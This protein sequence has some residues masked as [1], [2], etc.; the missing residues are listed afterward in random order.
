MVIRL[1]RKFLSC[2]NTGIILNLNKF[3]TESSISL[4]GRFHWLIVFTVMAGFLQYYFF[5]ILFE[6]VPQSI[7][8]VNSVCELAN[9]CF[10][11]HKIFFSVYFPLIFWPYS[12]SPLRYEGESV[13]VIIFLATSNLEV[14]H[15]SLEK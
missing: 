2:F 6:C 15:C 13:Q 1:C 5:F 4:G 10:S 9:E 14:L 11:A 8:L 12:L 3:S 7:E